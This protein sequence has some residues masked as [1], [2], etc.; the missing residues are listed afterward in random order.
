MIFKDRNRKMNS[1]SRILF[2]C[3]LISTLS[4]CKT[5]SVDKKEKIEVRPEGQKI[6]ESKQVSQYSKKEKVEK[7]EIMLAELVK[8]IRT[9]KNLSPLLEISD[10]YSRINLEE[11]WNSAIKTDYVEL[12][13]YIIYEEV[14]YLIK[15]GNRR[16]DK[17]GSFIDFGMGK[18]GYEY[19][20]SF[21]FNRQP[22]QWVLYDLVKR[23]PERSGSFWFKKEETPASDRDVVKLL[24]LEKLNALTKEQNNLTGV[25]SA[26]RRSFSF[27]DVVA[28]E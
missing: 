7:F 1:Y 9:V 5:I 19:G 24:A 3:S 11:Y 2:L 25:E 20:I 14:I 23:P 17:E 16:I 10:E 18:D 26:T 13:K 28:E 6:S 12:S 8:K 15:N 21:T 22:N 27:K 4:L